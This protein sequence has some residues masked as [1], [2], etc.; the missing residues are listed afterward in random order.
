MNAQKKRYARLRGP[1]QC[2]LHRILKNRTAGGTASAEAH[3]GHL[4]GD[5]IREAQALSSLTAEMTGSDP[6]NLPP[7]NASL[8]MRP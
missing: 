1:I 2:Q 7:Y 8:S 4:L 6:A 5:S 3:T